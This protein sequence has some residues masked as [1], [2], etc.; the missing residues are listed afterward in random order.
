MSSLEHRQPTFS[1]ACIEQNFITVS[2]ETPLKQAIEQMSRSHLSD[3]GDAAPTPFRASC[4]LVL[5]KQ[6]LIG[7]VTERDIV[8]LIAQGTAIE[9]RMVADVMT[10]QLIVCQESEIKDIIY[11]AQLMRQH[12]IRHLPVV[13]AEHHPI[14]IIT[15]T[16]LQATIEPAGLLKC[17]QVYEVMSKPVIYATPN[18][19]VLE[20]T[21]RMI[22]K[23]VSC[24]VIAEEQETGGIF[25]I[26]IVT[27]RDIIQFQ[28]LQIDFSQQRA[29]EVMSS[30][31]LSIHLEASLW[32]AY[33]Q[34]QQHKV[35]RLFVV[36]SQEK[37]VG[38]LTQTSV[39]KVI[40]STQMHEMIS[41]LQQ[42]VETLQT[43]KMLLLQNLNQNLEEQVN[44][45][46]TQ[47]ATQAQREKLLAEMALRIRASLN[48]NTILNTTVQ[49]V[50]QLLNSDRVVIY[51]FNSDWTGQVVVE[52]VSQSGFSILDRVVR[53]ECFQQAW[54]EHY[55]KRQS[56]VINDIYTANFSDC[57]LRFLEQFK[58]RSNLV[59]PIHVDEQ[60]W[61]LLIAHHCTESRCWQ[62]QEVSFLE[63]LSVQVAIAIQQ[64]VLLAKVQRMNGQLQAQVTRQT[65]E[66]EEA[67]EQLQQE[68][69][70]NL[71]IQT[72]L[73][74]SQ[75]QLARILDIAEDAIISINQSQQIILFN[76]GASKMFGYTRSEVIG[77]PL[78]ILLPESLKIRHRQHIQN[79]SQ[80]DTTARKM[81]DRTQA[82]LARRRDG[83][84]FLAEASISQLNT[85]NGIVLTVILR[86]VSERQKAQEKLKASE[87]KLRSILENIPSSI[88][89]VD[90][91]GQIRF[92]NHLNPDFSFSQVI[93]TS[94]DEDLP[95]ENQHTYRQ[96]I[97]QVFLSGEQVILETQKQNYSDGIT[98]Y[99]EVRIAPLYEN[100]QIQAAV[101]ISTDISARKQAE[102]AL[103]RQYQQALLL[104]KITEE[105]RQ[106]LNTQHI[107]E[108]TVLQVGEAFQASRCLIHSYSAEPEPQMPLVAEYLNGSYPSIRGIEI[109]V[110]GNPHAEFVLQQDR[111]SVIDHI[112]DEP[113]FKPV[114]HLCYQLQIKSIL[115]I[116]TSYQG[117][118]NGIIGI[119]QC[120]RYREWTVDEIKLL[121]DIAA[122]VG[123]ALAQAHSLKQEV[124]RAEELTHKNLALEKAK[125]EA[126]K[127]NAAKS[128]FLANMSHEIRTPMNAILGF[129][130]LLQSS[131]SDP[132]VKTYVD[133]I[134]A[135]GRTLL[136]LINDILD[137]SK[138]E[139]GK[140]E[141]HYEPTNLRS[142]VFEIQQIFQQKVLEKELQLYTEIDPNLPDGVE[143]DE[144]RIRQILFNVVGNAIKFTDSGSI[145]ITV[146]CHSSTAHQINL[147]I[148]VEDTG[149]GMTP[150]AQKKIFKAFTQSDGQST[151]KYGGTGLGLAITERLVHLLNGTIE[152]Q[153]KPGQG[154]TFCFRFP[155]LNITSTS[156]EP[157]LIIPVDDNLNQ[158]APVTILIVDDIASNRDLIAG[159]FFQTP[160]K[161]LFANDGQQAIRLAEIYQPDLI[162]MDLRMPHMDGLEATH[163]LKKCDQT[164]KIPIVILTAS[165][166]RLDEEELKHICE[167]FIRKPIS[168]SQLVGA[169][170]PLLRLSSQEQVQ[171]QNEG[172]SSDSLA[173]VQSLSSASFP[174]KSIRL[175]ELLSKLN[176]EAETSWQQLQLTMKT[177]DLEQFIERLQAW[178]E[179]HQSQKLAEYVHTLSQQLDQFD[180]DLL[181]QTVEQFTAVIESIKQEELGSV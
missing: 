90:R 60:L 102:I 35:R 159:Y 114:I 155:N 128:E 18:A 49:E 38:I 47:L 51:Q 74:E 23:P 111:A 24:I 147:E 179:E 89:V 141:L 105:I 50:R 149:I 164:R 133:T 48:L 140:L 103:E 148:R 131:V 106:S 161:L 10:Q 61:G 20:L 19:T 123:I 69:V 45:Q 44:T 8:R 57:H 43:E 25:P 36:N 41:L 144:V 32:S 31:L 6:Q 137:L 171:L 139:A 79:F 170:K 88:T 117:K 62:P 110:R 181:P 136:A 153:S 11:L 4:I 104:R 163:Y 93:G 160:H 46:A 30:S 5:E 99:E 118:P 3:S 124:D 67:N 33:Q 158:F 66:L 165:S 156:S 162:L 73:R 112:E 172:K 157:S 21:Q 83:S 26:G 68:W 77:E 100:E 135:S 116:R 130:D 14:G 180:W 34:M 58:V 65:Q 127:A 178:A 154:S 22:S 94:I 175:S 86:D 16:T 59:V 75:A 28:A 150:Q 97:E 27:E 98:Q 152:L 84:L 169:L 125:Q 138:I 174:E 7:L 142:I 37:L 63:S 101:V 81:G 56:K 9:Q 151:R 76:Q 53:D 126:E 119:H 107:F 145:K 82:I 173:P 12:Q 129:A 113:L 91:Q 17:R 70:E 120:D 54:F 29:A 109:P 176:Q 132:Q 2:P 143:L 177:R 108:T 42:Q 15:P 13:N 166:Q 72:A 80:S 87:E 92:L 122:Q 55:Q 95:L 121:E 39:L 78:D 134:V 168:R 146:S 167:G 85:Q 1:S 96:A 71:Q 115:S 52:S 64:A 40:D